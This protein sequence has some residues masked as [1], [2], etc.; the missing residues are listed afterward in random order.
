G[1]RGC[2]CSSRRRHTRFSRDWS[3]DV[4]SSDLLCLLLPVPGSKFAPYGFQLFLRAL[5]FPIIFQ[6][7][8]KFALSADARKAKSVSNGHTV[9]DRKSVVQG[10]SVELGGRPASTGQTARGAA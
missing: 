4:C 8:L 9:L 7:A 6:S 2:F 3:S 1:P 10:K 5:P